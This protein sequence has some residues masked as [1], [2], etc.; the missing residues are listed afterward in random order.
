MTAEMKLDVDDSIEAACRAAEAAALER[1]DDSEVAKFVGLSAR[2]EQALH[3]DD[4][5]ARRLRVESIDRRAAAR[6]TPL[7]QAALSAR[8]PVA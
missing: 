1:R 2:Y 7:V 6:L 8:S 4:V 3:A 5:V